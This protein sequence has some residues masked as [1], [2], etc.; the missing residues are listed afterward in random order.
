[1]TPQVFW[2]DGPWTGRLAISA[3]PRGGDW[4]E[5]EVRGWCRTGV[6]VIVSLL[7][8]DEERDLELGRE[9]ELCRAQG[10]RFVAF[11]V[12]DRS[13]PSSLTN[14]VELLRELREE[15]QAG[16]TVAIHCR[17]GI[18][19]SALIAAGLLVTAAVDPHAALLAVESARHLPVP[20][21]PEQRLWVERSLSD[22]LAVVR[23]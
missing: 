12:V 13:I 18:G 1:M 16:K 11:P 4:L 23:E 21:T 2:I 15:L 3:R 6:D 9:A 8:A 22:H 7:S 17:Q 19:R 14:T 5:D 20:E 10:M